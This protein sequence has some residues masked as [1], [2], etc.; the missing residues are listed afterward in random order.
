MAKKRVSP[1]FVEPM[2]CRPAAALPSGAGWSYELKF[3]GYRCLALKEKGVVTLLSRNAKDLGA[4]FPGVVEA[5]RSLKGE[6]VIDG[7]LVALDEQGRPAFQLLQNNQSTG[8]PVYFYAFDLLNRDGTDLLTRPIEER[9]AE[10]RDLF[11]NASDPLRLSALLAGSAQQVLAAVQQ[12]GLEGVVAKR[13]GSFYEPGERSGAWVK[14]RT[15]R[16]QEFVIGGYIPGARAF[17]A[18]LVGVYEAGQLRF[19]A[20]VKNGFVSRV[21]EAVLAKLKPL[22]QE[23]CPFTNLPEKKAHRWGDSLTA[24]KM[25]ECRWVQPL[26]VAQVAFVEWTAAGHLRHSS[27]VGLREDKEPRDAVREG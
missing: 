26:L 2:Q 11:A 7:E 20:K 10:L 17:D 18:L 27:F 16:E 3:D 9:R 13:D 4:R 6:W 25:R 19:V 22:V 15:N 24:E 5:L 12:L 23:D 8:A 1:R 14:M 21:R